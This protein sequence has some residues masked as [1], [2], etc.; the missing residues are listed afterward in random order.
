[1]SCFWA[2]Y[3]SSFWA[4]LGITFGIYIAGMILIAVAA[5]LRGLR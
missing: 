4:W 5:V 2:A 1:M 3:I